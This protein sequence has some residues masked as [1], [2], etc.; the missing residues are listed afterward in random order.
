MAYTLEDGDA[1]IALDDCF[2][3]NAEKLSGIDLIVIGTSDLEKSK[4]FFVTHMELNVVAEGTMDAASV[5][6]LYGQEG[7]A[8][9]DTSRFTT[10][11]ARW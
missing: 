5:K 3:Y 7:E 4:D 6:A 9:P 10:A 11:R 8:K 2:A 1:V